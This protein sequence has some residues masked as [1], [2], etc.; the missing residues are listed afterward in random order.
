MAF[1]RES[2]FIC[3]HLLSYVKSADVPDAFTD[4]VTVKVCERIHLQT[5]RDTKRDNVQKH[6]L[7]KH[8]KHA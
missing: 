8:R 1:K 3:W 7:N 2:S 4:H 5:K 6:A